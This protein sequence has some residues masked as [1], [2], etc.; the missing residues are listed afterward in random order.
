MQKGAQLGQQPLVP[1]GQVVQTDL[2]VGQQVVMPPP[3]L[4]LTPAAPVTSQH[5][6]HA[7][8][9]HTVPGG[10]HVVPQE[11]RGEGHEGPDVPVVELPVE[12][13]PDRCEQV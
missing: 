3:Q 11:V 1:S 13:V 8:L 6:A 7:P 4:A 2:E 10:Q 5:G 9:Q 12:P